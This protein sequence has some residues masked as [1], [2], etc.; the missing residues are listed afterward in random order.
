M[1]CTCGPTS[2]CK[3]KKCD[4]KKNSNS[5]D[6]DC[7]CKPHLCTNKSNLV[8]IKKKQ[9]QNKPA[10]RDNNAYNYSDDSSDDERL[11]STKFQT[12]FRPTKEPSLNK[13]PNKDYYDKE[14]HKLENQINPKRNNKPFNYEDDDDDDSE[15]FCVSDEEY[16]YVDSD[17]DSG[18]PN[19]V[20]MSQLRNK[21]DKHILQFSSSLIKN[22]LRKPFKKKD[23]QNVFK[24]R[25]DTDIYTEAHKKDLDDHSIDHIL[26]I[27][28]VGH[29]S[30]PI[31]YNNQ[32]V[33]PKIEKQLQNSLNIVENYNVTTQ[34]INV[35]KM[36]AF[37]KFLHDRMYRGYPLLSLMHGTKCEKYMGN[38]RDALVE[39]YENVN[40]EIRSNRQ[41]DYIT[42]NK[43][44]E[45]I[46]NELEDIF[47]Q[48]Q[49]H[50]MEEPPS[51]STRSKK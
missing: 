15:M 12:N 26:E 25:N 18:Y 3:T 23:L 32:S 50:N 20:T 4:C 2:G 47:N 9:E 38:I 10:Y 8:V 16:M 19:D 22:N 27:Q 31:L 44:F 30:A 28:V 46:G 11:R 45:E 17:S 41:G 42:G 40:R 13:K 14:L 48:M 24:Y 33:I 21:P 39:A 6:S 35:S 36:N 7:E 5:C 37:K 34:S 29:A 51:K 49:L 43:Y 1:V